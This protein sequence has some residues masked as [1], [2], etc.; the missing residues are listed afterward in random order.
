MN[1]LN[2]KCL[3]AGMQTTLQDKG[4]LGYQNKGIPLSGALDQYAYRYAN[5]LV[6]NK[7]DEPV[8]EI[9]LIGPR[10]EFDSDCKIAITGGNLSP[11]INKDP[12][13]MY[14]SLLVK[15]G[16]VLSFGK[17]ISGCRSY[18]AIGGSWQTPKWLGSVSPLLYVD[19]TS[20]PGYIQTDDI[21]TIDISQ[22]KDLRINVTQEINYSTDILEM[23]PGPEFNLFNRE[24][25]AQLFSTYFT[26]AQDSNRMGYKL[27]GP[28]ISSI[29]RN[30]LISTGIIPGTVQITANGTPIILMN[31][32]QT[33]GGYPRIGVI[34]S[35]SRDILAQ[36]K[37]GDQIRFVFMPDN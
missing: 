18:I 17:P 15:A 14:Q 5:V 27:I 11:M 8:Y 32:A 20:Q 10:L 12:I 36:K 28:N 13:P 21:V 24:G 22:R 31:D 37:P 26:I 6:N 30:E 29:S 33:I 16:D 2:V 23:H 9:T 1:M 35:I 25:I 3:K 4:R 7:L 34:N 19:Q